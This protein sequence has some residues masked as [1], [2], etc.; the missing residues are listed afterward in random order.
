MKAQRQATQVIVWGILAC[1]VW[2]VETWRAPSAGAAAGRVTHV[3]LYRGQALVTR[4]IDIE[5]EL[6]PLEVVVEGLPDQVVPESLFAEAGEGLDV[7]AVRFRSR[8]VKE[9]PRDELR[10]LQQSIEQ[11]QHQIDIN[12]K[13]QELL[14]KRSEYLDSLEAFVGPTATSDLS[15]GVLDAEA[16]QRITLFAFEQRQ[17]IAEAQVESQREAKQ[18]QQQLQLL[19][20]QHAELAASASRTVYEAVLFLE[21]QDEGGQNVRLSYLVNNCGW[22]PSY[23]VRDNQEA[24]VHLEYNALIH[25]LTGEDWNGVDL[26]LSTA[27]PAL[28]AAGPGLAPFRVS[29]TDQPAQ[30]TG[31]DER[32]LLSYAAENRRQQREALVQNQ[33][34]ISIPENFGSSWV[35]NE[36]A[37]RLQ[38][39][40]LIC[41]TDELRVIQ[42]DEPSANGPSLSYQLDSP[43]SLASRRDQQ[44]VRIMQTELPRE[45]Y[46]VASPVLTNYVYREADVRNSGPHDLLAGTVAVYLDGRFVGRTE[47]PT[48]AR[49]QTFVVG[50]GADP[51][52]RAY[53]ELV[54][55]DDAVQGGNRELRFR[56]RIRLENYKADAASVRVYDR[57]PVPERASE[58]R[59]RLAQT[60]DDLSENQLYV[61][62]ERSKG[63]LRWDVTVPQG[64]SGVSAQAIS[65]S[66][67]VEH[68]RNYHLSL[69]SSTPQ[70]RKEFEEL[71]R[72]RSKR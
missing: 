65:Y 63:I 44:M 5:G 25:Q 35:V 1:M 9:E 68:D 26:T 69:A 57:L 50:F 13:N 17:E 45:L 4:S 8:A 61:E 46:F 19:Q 24:M 43:V 54:S 66:Y 27:T 59:V 23:T 51:Q 2:G 72:D 67:T 36:A 64:S 70:L 58:V 39:L 62:R 3:T 37:N 22:S 16:L 14:T 30:Q 55:K 10:Q 53:R 11:V 48:V 15:K 12:A 47:I 71:Q 31:V 18:L 32:G 7:R 40:E 49:G 56:Y 41:T 60:S 21:K 33:A 29:L 20:R 34:A 42:A 6:G 38:H 52:L 28:S